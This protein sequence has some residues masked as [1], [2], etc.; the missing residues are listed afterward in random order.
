M[1]GEQLK[2]LLQHDNHGV[3][4][5]DGK[6]LLAEEGPAQIPIHGFHFRQPAEQLELAL[7]AERLSI[8]AGLDPLAQPVALLVARDVLDL[9]SDGGAVGL[10]QVGENLRQVFAGNP[11]SEHGRRNR[12]HQLGRQSVVHRI[13][14]GIAGGGAAQWLEPRCQMSVGAVRGDQRHAG[15]DGPQQFGFRRG[16]RRERRFGRL[17]GAAAGFRQAGRGGH[18]H[19]FEDRLIEAI[20][21]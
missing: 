6:R 11:H 7:R 4:T 20:G 13:E 9:I 8:A 18:L 21:A 10:T 19:G 15:G 16:R 3:E 12:L 1:I 2:R 5:F 14:R 17:A